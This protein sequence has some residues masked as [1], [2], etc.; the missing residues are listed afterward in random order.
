MK[1][2]LKIV[3]SF[4]LAVIASL[5]IHIADSGALSLDWLTTAIVFVSCFSIALISPALDRLNLDSAT[6]YGQSK[7]KNNKKES[8][9][10]KWFNVSKGYG[11]VTRETGEDVFVHFRSI[12]DKSVR[13]LRE[14]QGVKFTVIDGEKGPQAEEVELYN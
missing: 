4:V 7:S 10:V 8:G 11:F 12:R 14:G 5:L 6:E 2:L 13:S 9:K 1:L 3:S